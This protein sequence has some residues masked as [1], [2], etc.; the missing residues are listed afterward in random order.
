M[1]SLD[2]ARVVRQKTVDLITTLSIEQLNVIPTGFRNNIAW[3]LGHLVV[4]TQLLCYV[5][6]GVQAEGLIK[7][8]DKYRNGSKPESFIEQNEIDELSSLLLSSIDNI[9]ADY[10]KG[11]FNT[12][13]SYSTHTFGLPLQ[14]IEDVLVCCAMHDTVHWGNIMSMKKVITH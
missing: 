12:I 7:F 14:N 2:Y 8:A 4:S 3:H 13:E 6:T 1:Q 5:R 11:V 10:Q 9:E